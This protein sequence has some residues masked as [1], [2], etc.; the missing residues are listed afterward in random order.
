MVYIF[1]E[2]VRK[3]AIICLHA[4][5]RKGPNLVEHMLSHL[6]RALSDRDPSV[7]WGSLHLYHDLIKVSIIV[8]LVVLHMT[9]I[10]I[11]IVLYLL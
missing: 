9:I 4:F 11:I 7:V 10:H 6:P 1:R 3:K 5:W 2:V 8:H